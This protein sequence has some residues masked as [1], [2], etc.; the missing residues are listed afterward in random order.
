MN[1][2]YISTQSCITKYKWAIKNHQTL[3]KPTAWENQ[4]EQIGHSALEETKLIQET[5]LEKS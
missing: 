4:D 1:I 5:G 3:G 2:S